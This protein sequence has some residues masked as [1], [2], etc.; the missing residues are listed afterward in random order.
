MVFGWFLLPGCACEGG[1][2]G[3]LLGVHRWHCSSYLSANCAARVVFFWPQEVPCSEVPGRDGGQRHHMRAG[4]AIPCPIRRIR[5]T[6]VRY[7]KRKKKNAGQAAPS[8]SPTQAKNKRD[9]APHERAR[10][11]HH[12]E[13][14]QDP[15]QVGRQETAESLLREMSHSQFDSIEFDETDDHAD[16]YSAPV[17][18]VECAPLLPEPASSSFE[19]TQSSS[20]LAP[21]VL[22]TASSLRLAATSLQ[23]LASM[24]AM[25]PPKKF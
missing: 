17:V 15:R 18:S 1:P 20:E 24:P 7:G 19:T 2:T 10:P 4:W 13:K 16:L 12:P 5:R 25:Q 23:S 14:K 21:S 22:G 3:K 6:V 11:A 9:S 8:P